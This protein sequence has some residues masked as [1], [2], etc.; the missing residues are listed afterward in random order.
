MGWNLLADAGAERLGKL[1]KKT[2]SEKKKKHQADVL[3]PVDQVQPNRLS[4]ERSE[5][6]C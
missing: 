1:S 4:P 6:K 3:H 2:K 5:K